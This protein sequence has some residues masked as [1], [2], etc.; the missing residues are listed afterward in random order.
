MLFL[1]HGL[2]LEKFVR[3][4]LKL[5]GIGGGAFVKSRAYGGRSYPRS[6][7]QQILQPIL[8]HL[9]TRTL[10]DAIQP[11]FDLTDRDHMRSLGC[12]HVNVQR[13]RRSE[14]GVRETVTPEFGHGNYC[15]FVQAGRSDL[16]GVG[17]SFR[18]AERNRA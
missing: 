15:G 17:D 11:R 7:R 10:A 5:P 14:C 4:E 2:S 9:F 6:P 16:D 3:P 18:I 1:P 12:F 13:C 8:L